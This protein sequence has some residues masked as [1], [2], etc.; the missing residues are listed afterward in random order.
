MGNKR[1][2]EALQESPTPAD[3]TIL[4]DIMAVV[5]FLKDEGYKVGKSKVYKDRKAGL[6]KVAPDGSITESEALAYAVR[7][8][9]KKISDPAGRL[10]DI[11]AEKA[12]A[13]LAKLRA[14]EEKI[15]FE[16]DRERG[17]YLP[18]ADVRAELAMKIGAIEASVKHLLRTRGADYIWAVGGDGKKVQVFLD[19]FNTDFD[20]LLRQMADCDELGIKISI[21]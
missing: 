1:K 18:K 5:R 9:L 16:L 17:K 19:M 21:K 8:G 6:L 11:M 20:E 10:D 12:Q 4:K 13:E 14:Q 3:E 2:Q 15:R 7:A